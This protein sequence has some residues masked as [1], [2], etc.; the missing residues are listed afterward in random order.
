MNALVTGSNGFIGSFLVE[1]L[2]KEGF[3]VRCLVRRTSNLRWIN[4]LNIE[5]CYGELSDPASLGPAVQGIDIV[6]HLGGLTRGLK[7]D[8]YISGN[9]TTTQNLLNACL[10]NAPK[11]LKFVFVSS[12]AAGGPSLDGRPLTEDNANSPMSMYG[13]SK[14][15]AERAVMQF[16]QTRAATIVRPP[17]VYGP[18]DTD[19]YTLFKNARYGFLPIV[20]KGRQKISIIHVRDLVDGIF[21]AATQSQT[22]GEIFF[23]SSD[24]DVCFAE[25]ARIIGAALDKK[26]RLVNMPLPLIRAVVAVA[27]LVS[28]I[29][30]RPS[31]L[32][33]DKVAEMSQPV[34]LCSNEKAKRVLDFQPGIALQHGMRETAEWYKQHG[35]L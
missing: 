24:E 28:K 22:N 23:L 19:F 8:D 9:V 34:W 29:T 33:K 15:L 13:R 14:F 6:F 4:D 30:K 12:Q 31:I 7:E 5:L 27:S 18:R 21:L 32:N 35:W 26:I 3:S 2:L 10:D 1:K 25:L 20:G 11:H 17:S 16:A